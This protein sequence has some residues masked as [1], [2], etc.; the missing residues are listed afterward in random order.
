MNALIANAYPV[1]GA[2]GIDVLEKVRA[3]LSGG[4]VFLG[5]AMIVWGAVSVGVNVREGSSG[6]GSAIAGAVGLIIGGA[7][8]CAA[9]I[10][11]KTL[12][13]SWASAA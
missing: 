9:A 13:I 7:I 11:F 8:I 1:L 10:F 2:T 12:D 3:L 6:N 5:G 4:L